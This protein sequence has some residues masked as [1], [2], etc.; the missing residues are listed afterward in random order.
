V[1]RGLLGAGGLSLAERHLVVIPDVPGLG[2][3]DPVEG[4]DATSFATWFDALLEL[5]CDE[6]PGPGRALAADHARG[7]LRDPAWM[8]A[9][10]AYTLSRA[11]VPH[12]KRTMRHLFGTCTKRVAD[13]ELRRIGV[14]T[15][16]L[17]GR[18]DRF[19]PLRLAEEA[20]SRLGWPLHVLDA[21]GHVPHIE[22][23]EAFLDALA[24]SGAV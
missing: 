19:V 24:R 10:D 3:S 18:H 4:L 2:E 5:T 16:L 13:G 6:P 22:R 14:P 9:F 20:A 17:W 15:A 7:A 1:R 11:T 21:T 8:V 23:P 12:V